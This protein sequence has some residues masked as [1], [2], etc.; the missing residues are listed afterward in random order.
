IPNLSDMRQNLWPLVTA[1]FIV[2]L[3]M[4]PRNGRK[5]RQHLSVSRETVEDSLAPL[6]DLECR[7]PQFG[8]LLLLLRRSRSHCQTASGCQVALPTGVARRD[9]ARSGVRAMWASSW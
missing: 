6:P 1:D 8:G 2:A 7:E 3:S 4:E 5:L 9:R